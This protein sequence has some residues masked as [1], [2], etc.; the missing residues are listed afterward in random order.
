MSSESLAP[1]TGEGVRQSMSAKI[2][3]TDDPIET[4]PRRLV[5][6]T[7]MARLG[8]GTRCLRPAGSGTPGRLDDEPSRLSVQLDL[9]GQLRL[10]Q[11][12]ALVLPQADF[13]GRTVGASRRNHYP[14]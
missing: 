10:V 9:V 5:E 13:V 3:Y 1:A 11:E 8:H 12:M 2:R 6:Q 14:Y 4:G 7:V